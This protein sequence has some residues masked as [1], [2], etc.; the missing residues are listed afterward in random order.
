MYEKSSGQAIGFA[1]MEEMEPGVYEDM[2]IALGPD[3]V[4]RGYGK[5][6]VN[7]MVDLHIPIPKIGLTLELGRTLC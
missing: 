6:I 5:Q 2:G 7:A 1:G 4:G 3:F